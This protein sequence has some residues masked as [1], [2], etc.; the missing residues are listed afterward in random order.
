VGRGP[1]KPPVLEQNRLVPLQPLFHLSLS[2]IPD[3]GVH[4]ADSANVRFKG[5]PSGDVG[6]TRNSIDS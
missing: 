5:T 6:L 3:N 1:Q 4:S 2:D